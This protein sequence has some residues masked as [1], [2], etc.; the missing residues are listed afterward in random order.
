MVFYFMM[1]QKCTHLSILFFHFQYSIQQIQFCP[2]TT[3]LN[4]S[5]HI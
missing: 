1:V 2:T 3:K 4:F 5:E